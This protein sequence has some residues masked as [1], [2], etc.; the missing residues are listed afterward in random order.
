MYKGKKVSVVLTSYKERNSIKEIING[1]FDTGIVD[2]VVVVDNNA[3]EGS[4]EEIKKT[5]AKLFFEKR[6][7][8]GYALRRGMLEAMGDYIVLCEG[9]GTYKPIDIEKFL[10]Y[11]ADFSVVLGTR[12]NTSLIGPD[13]GMFFLR[14]I[15]DVIEGKLIEIL[16]TTNRLTDVGCTYKLLSKEIVRQLEKCWLKGDSHFVTEMTLQVAARNISFVEIPVSF[17]QRVGVSAVTESFSNIVKWG[18]KLF[19]FIIF[20]RIY[21]MVHRKHSNE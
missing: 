11:A 4:V 21:W 17:R 2:E 8:Q 14:R 5:Q 18:I 20:F 19:F 1:F 13:S 6:Q 10:L 12:T 9:D 7:G 15:A 16:F 3:E